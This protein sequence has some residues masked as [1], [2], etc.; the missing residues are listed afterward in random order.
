MQRVVYASSSSV[1][2]DSEELP[3]R[4]DFEGRPRS[5]YAASKRFCEE[6][7]G[8][9]A[10]CHELEA[11]GLRYY[12]VYGPRQSPDGPY[13]AVNLAAS[14]GR[15]VGPTFHPGTSRSAPSTSGTP[16]PT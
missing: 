3:K 5:P 9:F 4:E 15:T 7:A 6:I 10:R 13:A 14:I 8:L 12:Y 11:I 1:Y 2:G 16:W